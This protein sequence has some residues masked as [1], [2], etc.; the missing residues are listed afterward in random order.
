LRDWQGKRSKRYFVSKDT[1]SRSP[2]VTKCQ[3]RSNLAYD[4][5]K[6][7]VRLLVKM[8]SP[9]PGTIPR[10]LREPDNLGGWR[11]GHATRTFPGSLW[12]IMAVQRHSTAKPRSCPMFFSSLSV[13]ENNVQIADGNCF[14]SRACV[15]NG[16]IRPSHSC[17]YMWLARRVNHLQNSH[18][19]SCE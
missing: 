18:P 6:F 14:H 7:Q 17:R 8:L 9:P 11:F 13:C 2:I 4:C 15:S 3:I 19:T 16:S 12:S 5:K 1:L 10:L